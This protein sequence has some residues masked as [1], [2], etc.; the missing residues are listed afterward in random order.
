MEF[1]QIYSTYFR[2]VYLYAMQLCG[3]EHSFVIRCNPNWA[4]GS[5]KT[6]NMEVC[7]LEQ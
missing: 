7:T 1:E 2:S 4:F 5:S 6:I 3:N